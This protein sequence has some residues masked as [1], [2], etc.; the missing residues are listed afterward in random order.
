MTGHFPSRFFG[1]ERNS[2]FCQFYSGPE[3]AK[4]PH[5]TLLPS[6]LTVDMMFLLWNTQL[7]LLRFFAEIRRGKFISMVLTDCAVCLLSDLCILN[8]VNLGQC[9]L[10]ARNITFEHVLPI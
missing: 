6:G 3:A 2:L 7:A 5:I 1:R 10:D 8:F 9:A 4:H